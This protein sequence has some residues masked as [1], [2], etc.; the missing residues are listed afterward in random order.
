MLPLR[1][2]LSCLIPKLRPQPHPYPHPHAHT[3]VSYK[4]EDLLCP[5]DDKEGDTSDAT[6]T[7]EQEES[8]QT[9]DYEP[10]DLIVEE[11]KDKKVATI[12][13]ETKREAVGKKRKLE[14]DADLPPS[15]K[16]TLSLA[17]KT[18]AVDVPE[19]DSKKESKVCE[20]GKSVNEQEAEAA[21]ASKSAA[22]VD[23]PS[24]VKKDSMEENLI[25]QICQV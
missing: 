10:E 8:E 11:E 19:A 13:S 1:C 20:E 12:H 4:F 7:Y 6:L 15:A 9:L 22:G 16:R 2:S 3:D 25:C 23:K 5:P 14:E 18:A 24:S 21:Q 17:K